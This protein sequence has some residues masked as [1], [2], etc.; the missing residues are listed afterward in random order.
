LP[1]FGILYITDKVKTL[2]IQPKIWKIKPI[3]Y[4][5]MLQSLTACNAPAGDDFSRIFGQQISDLAILSIFLS[6]LTRFFRQKNGTVRRLEL[7]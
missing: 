6:D 7:Y 2:I 3:V 4:R 1:L 5:I